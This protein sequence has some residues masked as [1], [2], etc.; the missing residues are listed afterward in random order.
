MYLSFIRHGQTDWNKQLRWQSRSDIPLN[1]TGEAQAVK[2]SR[3]LK[4]S[5]H[6]PRAVV[7][8]PMQ[9]A[10]STA[11]CIAKVSGIEVIA[12]PAFLELELGEFEGKTTAALQLEYG[13]VFEN[14]LKSYHAKAP[15]GGESIDQAIL[16][17]R[18][19][20]LSRMQ[21]FG[22][23]LVIVAHQAILIAMKA[24]LSGDTAI[25]TLATYKQANDEIDIWDINRAKISQ[26]IDIRGQRVDG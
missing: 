10:M 15:P 14:W 4:N 24:A 18:P 1:E 21:E 25:D 6:R 17:M 7:S 8:S 19:T 2:I 3:F 13:D 22:D 20:L 26:R 16:R 9:R 11:R 23:G 5:N 12:E